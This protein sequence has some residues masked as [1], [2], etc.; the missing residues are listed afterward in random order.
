MPKKPTLS[1]KDLSLLS[2]LMS[3]EQLAATK[4]QMYSQS[5]TDPTLKEICKTLEQNHNKNFQDLFN[6]L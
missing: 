6:L 1:Q 5:L 3:Y 4:S 2:D